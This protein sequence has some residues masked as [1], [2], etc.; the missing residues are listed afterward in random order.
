MYAKT[1][2]FFFIFKWKSFSSIKENPYIYYSHISFI[3]DQ[4]EEIKDDMKDMKKIINILVP[5]VESQVKPEGIVP[6]AL[7]RLKLFYKVLLVTIKLT[8][9]VS[10]F[11]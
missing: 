3:V 2:V 4:V 10:F 9:S 5:I 11:R 8:N 1:Q 7:L 6:P